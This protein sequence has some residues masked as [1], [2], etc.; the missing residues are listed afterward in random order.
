MSGAEDYNLTWAAEDLARATRLYARACQTG[1]PVNES[2]ER[3]GY[4]WRLIARWGSLPDGRPD[5]YLK[6]YR[7]DP[8]C[9][10]RF[11]WHGGAWFLVRRIDAQLNW[12][13]FHYA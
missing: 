1:D 9:A 7:R 3:D 5:A 11:K 2:W 10:L 13:F 4:T 6:A 12:S 8:R